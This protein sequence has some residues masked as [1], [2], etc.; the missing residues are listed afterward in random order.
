MIFFLSKENLRR[1]SFIFK[2]CVLLL[3][4][5]IGAC[6]QHA[7]SSETV[8][9]EVGDYMY[10]AEVVKTDTKSDSQIQVHIFNDIIRQQI[11]N[12]VSPTKIVATRR[13]PPEGWG[14]RQV[15][16]Q[17]FWNQEWIYTED[18]TEFEGHYI[19]PIKIEEN[20]KI[21]IEHIRFPIPVS[22]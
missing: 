3:I 19:I 2:T 12:W 16:V 10:P 1:D 22:R 7:M 4:I 11:G 14:T 6:D 5:C 20:R 17:Y 15:A 18:A 21:E 8:L 9:I 13:K